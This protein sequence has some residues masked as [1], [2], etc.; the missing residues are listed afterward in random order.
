MKMAVFAEPERSEVL[1]SKS[2][3]PTKRLAFRELEKRLIRR[4]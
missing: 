1:G 3:L 2:D 4:Q